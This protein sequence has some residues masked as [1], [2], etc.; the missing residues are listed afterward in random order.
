MR[1]AFTLIE[2][3]VV[4][5]IIALLAGL[6]LPGLASARRTARATVGFAN[7]RSLS[8]IMA[9][10]TGDYAD[11]FLNPFRPAWPESEPYRGM[12]WSM[13][14]AANDPEQRWDFIDKCCPPLSTEGFGGVWYSY[15]AEYRGGTRFDREMLSPAD[16]HLVAEH[17][18][19]ELRDE[20]RNGEILL[21][22]SFP[23]SPTF[24][25]KP[26]RY[27]SS[28]RGDMGPDMIE[29]QYISSVA[30]PAAKVMIWERGDFSSGRAPTG[31][32][33]PRS[34]IAVGLVDGSCD[35]IDMGRLQEDMLNHADLIAT[36]TCCPPPPEKPHLFAATFRGVQGR[37]IHR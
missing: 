28:C 30:Y 24:W 36:I 6:L 12:T 25:S 33:N 18:Q 11:A 32:H 14:H 5:G 23:Y 16:G 3:L 20:V 26:M 31:L 37:D 21:P 4:I 9:V 13:V 15:L 22:T 2:L 10:Y 1:R 34:R 7:L 27:F 17:R 35:K 19:A 8:Q 29:T